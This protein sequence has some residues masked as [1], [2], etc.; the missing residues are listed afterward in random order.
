M[1]YP[2]YNLHLIVGEMC[3]REKTCGSKIRLP[4][5]STAN[6]IALKMTHKYHR[7]MQGYP[8]PFCG[9]WHIG[10]KMSLR[11]LMRMTWNGFGHN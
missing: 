4:K 3:G 6:K 9:G 8:C 5:E 1:Q 7:E 11:D 10:G 2:E